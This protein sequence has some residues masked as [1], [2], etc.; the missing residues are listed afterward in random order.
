ME[1]NRSPI[2]N[3]LL[4]LAIEAERIERSTIGEMQADLTSRILFLADFRIYMSSLRLRILE[5][6]KNE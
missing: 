1:T 5:Q 4:D 3:E 6:L 2:L